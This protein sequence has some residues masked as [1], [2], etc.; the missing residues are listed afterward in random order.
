M[1]VSG[2]GSQKSF[3]DVGLPPT[4][5]RLCGLCTFGRKKTSYTHSCRYILAAVIVVLV[6]D[7]VVIMGIGIVGECVP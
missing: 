7:V 4:R 3:F 1:S 6:S 5:L 2:S